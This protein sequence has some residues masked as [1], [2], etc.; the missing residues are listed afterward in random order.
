MKRL[1]LFGFLL[2]I[3]FL[4]Q[5]DAQAYNPLLGMTNEWNIVTSVFEGV[6]TYKYYANRDTIIDTLKYKI[7]EEPFND[8]YLIHGYLRED[9]INRRVYIRTDSTLTGINEE[10]VYLDFSIEIGDT[11]EL[12]NVNWRGV[13][14]LKK[15]M[16]DSINY[17]S[18]NS[19]D[20]KA[21]YLSGEHYYNS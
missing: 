12:F 10:F 15:F 4:V 2:G 7:L 20:R 11:I 9:T 3:I 5:L 14:T 6:E 8:T 18:T 16:V 21:I 17:I 1:K 13:D 19:G